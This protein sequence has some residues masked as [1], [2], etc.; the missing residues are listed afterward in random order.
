MIGNISLIRLVVVS[1][2]IRSHLWS[3][4]LVLSVEELGQGSSL[5]LMD[6]GGR[7]KENGKKK[8]KF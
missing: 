2:C 8:L 4:G 6:A 3:F 1:V 7:R 5:N